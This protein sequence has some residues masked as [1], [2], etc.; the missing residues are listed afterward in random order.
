M[1]IL[2]VCVGTLKEPYWREA[3]DEYRKRL[4]RYCA[5]T[6]DEVKEARAPARPSPAEARAAKDAEG[7]AILRRVKNESHVVALDMRGA[8]LSSEAFA[9][10]L[11]AL[12][13]A[14]ADHVT[15]ITGGPLGLADAVLARA[16]LRLSLSAM[17]LPHR[18]AR[19]VLLEQ[20]YRAFTILR[21]E[22]YHK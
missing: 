17:T 18:L 7:I 1:N 11:A 13:H 4:G 20:L 19:V 8:A 9:E 15:F 5:L 3:A 21:G 12:P 6:T 22:A 10:K 2:L 14:G 16:D